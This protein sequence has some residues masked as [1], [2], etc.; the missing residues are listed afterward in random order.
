MSVD[1]TTH[2]H[3]LAC[4]SWFRHHTQKDIC[5]KPVTV[6]ECDLF[7]VTN[8]LIV[9]HIKCRTVSLI[10]KLDDVYGNVLFISPYL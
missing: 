6:W 7:D 5:G 1:G 2:S 10:D 8:F 4:L 3:I 9:Q